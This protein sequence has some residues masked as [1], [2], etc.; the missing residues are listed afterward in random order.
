MIC[1]KRKIVYIHI[2]KTAG[3]SVEKLLFPKYNFNETPNYEICYGWDENFGWLNHLTMREFEVLFPNL[4]IHDFLVFTVV[5]NPWDRIVSEFFWK[6][7][8]SKMEMS[9]SDFVYRIYKKDYEIIQSFYKSPIALMQH[10]KK[11]TNY[12]SKEFEGDITIIRFE[13]F[14]REFT[15]FCI[16]KYLKI[17]KIPNL[18]RSIHI[19]YKAYY[20]K[21]TIGMIKDLY[22]EDIER[23]RYSFS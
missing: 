22:Q 7:S 20:N 5:R 4:D 11:Q 10:I 18:R 23:F 15:N 6:S 3:T 21:N 8:T 19:N 16:S 12:I 2:P 14:H 13:D 9:F 17:N 1:K